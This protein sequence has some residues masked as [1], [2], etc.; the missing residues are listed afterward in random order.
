MRDFHIPKLESGN[1][2]DFVFNPSFAL[3][4]TLWLAVGEKNIGVIAT[5]DKND[6]GLFAAL[7]LWSVGVGSILSRSTISDDFHE[8]VTHDQIP[9]R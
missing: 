1:W 7:R 2:G 6:R 3:T 9:S 8:I 5:Y 4:E